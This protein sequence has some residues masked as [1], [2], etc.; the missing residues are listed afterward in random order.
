MSHKENIYNILPKHKRL[1]ANILNVDL[2]FCKFDLQPL[3]IHVTNGTMKLLLTFSW[4]IILHNIILE[5][6]CDDD[7]K[8][9]EPNVGI[10]FWKWLFYATFRQGTKSI[11]NSNMYFET[12]QWP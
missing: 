6:E 1:P 11:E 5:D 8:V 2:E 3:Q 7:V 4:C 9:T 10:Q 12:T